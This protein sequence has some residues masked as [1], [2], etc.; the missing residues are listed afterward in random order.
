[1]FWDK[2]MMEDKILS[3]TTAVSSEIIN[4][5]SVVLCQPRLLFT[6]GLT[7]TL[8][9]IVFTRRTMRNPNKFILVGLSFA[10]L[11]K[12]LEYIPYAIYPTLPNSRTDAWNVCVLFPSNFSQVCH[13][14]LILLT[15]L[16]VCWR[17]VMISN[18]GRGPTLC[19]MERARW[20]VTTIY[21]SSTILC[22]PVYLPFSVNLLHRE[23]SKYVVKLSELAEHNPELIRTNFWF[24]SVIIKII[25]CILLTAVSHCLIYS[26]IQANK[27]KRS[28]LSKPVIPT[29]SKESLISI[30][31]R[32]S[33]GEIRMSSDLVTKMLLAGNLLFLLT[34]FPEGV[35]GL[36]SAMLGNGFFGTCYIPLADL[37]AL[38]NSVLLYLM[39]SR[40]QETL[41]RMF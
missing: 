18:Y 41:G 35:P 37:M 13:T 14:V 34:E 4:E 27:G 9:L 6:R 24:Y 31:A 22:I 20:E 16:L 21:I 5:S 7:N 23:S 10:D 17:Y 15:D 2:N 8:N 1:F 36:A 33:S 29:I 11:L 38:L 12:T 32:V 40:F 19:N 3:L 39:S 26:I 28:L 30:S 25:P